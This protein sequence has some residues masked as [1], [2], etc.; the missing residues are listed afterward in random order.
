MLNEPKLNQ[1]NLS[2]TNSFSRVSPYSPHYSKITDGFIS[3][4]PTLANQTIDPT[5]NQ[6]LQTPGTRV[7]NR[8][9]LQ[10]Q[11]NNFNNRS[12]TLNPNQLNIAD[13]A[14]VIDTSNLQ[15]QKRTRSISRSLRS[16]F[17]RSSSS[18]KPVTHKREK[19]YDVPS[20]NVGNYDIHSGKLKFYSYKNE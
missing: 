11:A 17:T 2:A 4:H 8:N 16:L 14:L 15:E 5:T 7:I 19:S 20:I 13:G 9:Y 10:V 6:P 12:N 1:E 18:S 3:N